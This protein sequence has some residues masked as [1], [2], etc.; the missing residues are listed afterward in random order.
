MPSL[1]APSDDLSLT[2][3][4]PE[5]AIPAPVTLQDLRTG[6]L[7][8]LG[9]LAIMSGI[10]KES[11]EGR[12]YVSKV[13]LSEDEHDLTFHGG[14]D[15]ALHQYS[16][17]N[18]AYWQGRFPEPD[19]A[20]NFR[21]GGFGENLVATG[22][23]ELNVCIGDRVRVGVPGSLTVGGY[24]GCLLEVSLPRQPCFKLNQKFGVK[25]FAKYV[26]ET[27]RSGWYYRIIEEGWVEKGMEIRVVER[28]FPRWTIERLQWYSHNDTKNLQVL[29]EL[30][31]IDE[32]GE[33]AQWLFRNRLS[34]IKQELNGGREKVHEV[35][36]EFRIAEKRQETPRICVIV[37][38]EVTDE[39][40]P[41]AGEEDDID[42]GSHAR[43]KLPN[44]LIRAYSVV[45]GA[46]GRF[47]LGVARHPSSRG[48]SQWICD[49]AQVGDRVQVGRIRDGLKVANMASHHILLAGGVGITAF[50]LMIKLFEL[51]HLNFDLHYAVRSA[52]D[53]A[54]ASQLAHSGTRVTLYDGSRGQ[55]MD[56]AAILRARKWNSHAY[57]CGPQRMMDETQRAAKA[58]GMPADEVHFEAFAAVMSGDAFT[59]DVE[60]G[61][62]HARARLDVGENQTLLEVM[63]AAGFDAPSSCEAG[64]CGTCKVGVA[65]GRVE[66][67]GTALSEEEKAGA[68]LSC[69]SRGVGHIAVEILA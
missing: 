33:E 37:L 60:D 30:V 45:S 58:C 11:R 66:H 31:V 3:S 41:P 44:G 43:L 1:E 20:S 26:I 17:D 63:R 25:N 23:S 55:R 62:T 64:N 57:V 42:P 56:I 39:V 10:I 6:K 13:G 46:Q 34:S 59:A 29:E 35:W 27:R 68:M 4:D 51:I 5:V 54:F 69:V 18:Y 14:P 8:P 36:R 28:R 9:S 24:N 19:V 15:K 49:T 7:K 65:S 38:E 48:G 22:L 16:L 47:T 2:K 50:M 53:V 40:K 32:I 21:G 52:D 12:V 61:A 67:R